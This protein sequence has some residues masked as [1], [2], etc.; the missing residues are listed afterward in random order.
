M[1]ICQVRQVSFVGLLTFYFVSF[2]TLESTD[3]KSLQMV[4]QDLS[5]LGQGMS[6]LSRHVL[7]NCHVWTR[8]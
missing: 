3:D 8:I 2:F 4:A 7:K 5:N 1:A 6:S